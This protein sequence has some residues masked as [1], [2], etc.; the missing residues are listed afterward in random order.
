MGGISNRR[1]NSNARRIYFR[2]TQLESKRR[3]YVKA[4]TDRIASDMTS[5]SRI[6]TDISTDQRI[7]INEKALRIVKLMTNNGLDTAKIEAV[8]SLLK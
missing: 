8:T 4:I 1:T 7:K 6:K 3:M 2:H 5:L